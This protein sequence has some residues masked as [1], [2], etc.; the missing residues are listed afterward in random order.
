MKTPDLIH[1]DFA[2]INFRLLHYF[3]VVAQELSFS[4]AAQRLNMSQPPLSLHVKELE[5]TLDTQLFVRT[6]RSVALTPAGRALLR[7]VEKLLDQ[8]S[9][10]LWHVRQLGRGA[11]GHMVIG[12][13]GT[14]VWG[15]LL[16][17]LRHFVAQ[18][19]GATWS[20]NELSPTRQIEALQQHRIDL[21]IWREAQSGL[22]PDL[23]CQLLGKE[24]IVLAV[25]SEHPLAQTPHVPLATL[26]QEDMVLLPAQ[27]SSLGAYLHNACRQQGF[28]PRISHQVNEPQTALALVADGYGVTLLPES[29]ARIAWPGVSFCALA[30]PLPANLY[31]VYDAH[32]VTPVV[33]GFLDM[34]RDEQGA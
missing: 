4:K 25:S 22:P 20:L 14:A 32:T 11:A 10:S 30:E 18:V 3:R 24:N 6:T 21:G 16:P 34:L 8:A 19:P 29:C 13:V 1:P 33:Q 5:A 23:S 12:A 9:S 27:A 7:D 28:V 2:R 17:S 31:A 15:A 26:A